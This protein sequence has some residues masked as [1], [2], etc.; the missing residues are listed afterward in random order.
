M[1]AIRFGLIAATAWAA[2]SLTGCGSSN[3]G[4]MTGGLDKSERYVR[5]GDTGAAGAAPT[6]SGGLAAL[7]VGGRAFGHE[8]V[9][10]RLAEA[11]GDVVVDEMVLEAQLERRFEARGWTLT[12]ADVSR[13]ERLFT[14][15]LSLAGVTTDA[16]EGRRLLA[17]VRDAR[18]LGPAR[19]RSL[20]RR[21]A[22][23]RRLVADGVELTSASVELAWAL[24]YGPRHEARII[25]VPTAAEAQRA[26]RRVRGGE[27]FASVASSLSTDASAGRGGLLSPFSLEDATYPY[28]VRQALRGMS[29]GD[30]SSPVSLESGYAIVLLERVIP[31]SPGA[32]ARDSDAVRR[33]ARLA[34]ERLL[35]NQ[36][37][38][39][40]VAE[41]SVDVLDRGLKRGLDGR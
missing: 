16:D 8:E 12:D 39:E 6:A 23:L 3:G 7:R 18:G 17:Q 22:M 38:R 35:M 11:S 25:T 28:A 14:D 24:R 26:V 9:M 29:E 13:E 2:A 1:D 30:V 10:T 19:Y 27:S 41:A 20:L 31:A 40:L 33:E 37:A 5:R 36:L 15:A 34:Q 32:P 21:T 4:G